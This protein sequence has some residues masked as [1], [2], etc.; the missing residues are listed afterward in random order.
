MVVI[1]GAGLAGLSAA[2]FLGKIPYRL[3]ER[4]ATVGGLCRSHEVNGFTFDET[5]HVLHCKTAAM[6][7]LVE[8]LLGD[9]LLPH[10]RQSAVFSKNTLTPYPFQVHLHGLPQETVRDCLEGYVSALVSSRKLPPSGSFKGWILANFGAGIAHHFMVPF[11]EKLWNVP[12]EELTTE[13]TSLVPRPP[14]RDVINGALGIND[15]EFGYN[16][17]FSY[18]RVGGIQSLPLAFLQRVGPVEH[19]KEVLEVDT[20]QRRVRC[21]DGS[22]FEYESLVSTM[23]LPVLVQRCIDLPKRIREASLKLRWTSVYA[24]NLAINRANISSK[25][26]IYFPEDV[27]PFYRAGFPMNLSPKM[28]KRG[29]S[30]IA[31]EVSHRPEASVPPAQL[32]KRTRAGLV[33]AGIF[34]PDDALVASEVRDIPYAYVIFDRIRARIVPMIL[35]ELERRGIHS[36]GRYG[37]WEHTSMETA[38][39]QGKETAKALRRAV[40]LT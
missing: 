34:Q 38:M 32:I 4:E 10:A 1:I 20:K 27:F 3:L 37:R 26:W 5:G 13:W 14:L 7:R 29:A 23:P 11:N 40:A 28:G 33:R 18:P 35:E 22:T 39:Q 6:R 21:S 24:V 2:S 25:H 30:S 12:L 19:H 15:K 31:A 8:G 36:I 17:Q 9:D 16:T